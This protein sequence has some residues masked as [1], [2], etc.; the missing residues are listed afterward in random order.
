MGNFHKIVGVIDNSIEKLVE[1]LI[2]IVLGV[3]L[4]LILIEII[5]RYFF[6]MSRSYM[7]ELP[8]YSLPV[9][10]FLMMGILLKRGSHVAVEILPERL[11][12]RAKA[13]AGLKGV[14]NLVTAVGAFGLLYASILIVQFTYKAGRLTRM[15]FDIPTWILYVLLIPGSGILILF[16]LLAAIKEFKQV[17]SGPAPSNEG[18]RQ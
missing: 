10:T 13:A 12:N 9:I 17:L 5:T 3:D 1:G 6:A 8:K 16:A 11:K 2:C 15:E 18:Q 4:V 14:I 7:E